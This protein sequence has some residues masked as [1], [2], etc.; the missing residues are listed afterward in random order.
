MKINIKKFQELCDEGLLSCQKHPTEDFL[1]WNYTQKCQFARNWT[2]D[3]MMARGLITNSAGE[4]LYRPFKKFFNYDEHQGDDCVLPPLPV[5]PFTVTGKIDGS[6]G[7]M[8]WVDGKPFIATRGSFTSDQAI[9][10]TKIIQNKYADYDFIQGFTYLFEIIYPENRIVVDYGKTDDLYLL[11]IIVTGSGEEISI[12]DPDQYPFP[13]APQ[14]DYTDIS[15]I[16]EV[17]KDNEEGFVIRY[18]SGVRTKI[19]MAEYVR[20][21]RLVT[22]VNAKTIWELLMNNQKFD[23]LLDRVPDEFYTWVKETKKKIQD[24]FDIVEAVAFRDFASINKLPTRRE[25]AEAIIKIDASRE[26]KLSGIIFS[27]LDGKPYQ[28]IIWKMIRPRADKPWKEDE[29]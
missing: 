17:Q 19:K 1:I 18:R 21:H 15:E 23:E 20:L 8:Y 16:K 29:V 27:M 25:Q 2:T 6:L 22:G 28:S 7:I 13:C 3:T 4:I 14:Y 11:A 5:E 24:E 9:H 10:A 12:G 26:K